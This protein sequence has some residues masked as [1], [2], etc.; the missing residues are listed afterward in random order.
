MDKPCRENFKVVILKLKGPTLD[1][2]IK[3]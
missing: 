2:E 3:Y 1:I